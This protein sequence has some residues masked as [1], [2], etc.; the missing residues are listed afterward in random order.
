MS[1]AS[2][3][4]RKSKG[5]LL[6]EYVI[7]VM[8]LLFT[9]SLNVSMLY[10]T[11]FGIFRVHASSF[12]AFLTDCNKIV[13]YKIIC[14]YGFRPSKPGLCVQCKCRTKPEGM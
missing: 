8:L 12:F 10:F 11:W 14:P 7:W 2:H 5:W 13:Q 1:I 3:F 4:K 6:K 9:I